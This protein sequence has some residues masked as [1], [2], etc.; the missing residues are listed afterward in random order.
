MEKD[1]KFLSCS[2]AQFKEVFPSLDDYETKDEIE[3]Y[4]SPIKSPKDCGKLIKELAFH[5]PLKKGNSNNTSPSD[6]STCLGHLRR[7][8][9][10]RNI[11]KD[12]QMY[13]KNNNNNPNDQ[14][15]DSQQPK[16]RSKTSTENHLK[17]KQD[18][19]KSPDIFLE[20][21][22]GSVD[23]ID[24]I[25]ASKNGCNVSR[26]VDQYHLELIKR[27]LPGRP[28]QSQAEL[29]DWNDRNDGLGWWPT[30]FFHKQTREFKLQELE[31]SNEEIEDMRNGMIRANCDSEQS[32]KQW[33]EYCLDNEIQ[34]SPKKFPGV[35]IICP[36][37][38]DVVSMASDERRLQIQQMNESL[39]NQGNKSKNS[40]LFPD[41]ANPL[42]TPFI[43]AIQGVSRMERRVACRQGIE[44]SA[45]QNGQ[46]KNIHTKDD[47]CFT[48]FEFYH[49]N[50]PYYINI[51]K[52]IRLPNYPL[53]SII[54][55]MLVLMHRVRILF[56][57]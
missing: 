16:K 29:D 37:T 48:T 33:Y 1:N 23:E 52:H 12:D 20:V 46:V 8:R 40:T 13:S 31:L 19:T 2:K 32:K 47:S 50:P 21:L 44:S 14:D 43:L 3:V 49:L 18:K 24:H 25:L 53:F 6:N 9:R 36:K 4:I 30:I 54:S 22:L 11:K 35:V 42:C 38:K 15:D 45:F 28:A 56:K 51:I 41:L 27:M 34:L 55:S 26:I 17:Q 5:L 39:D 57:K 7:V 10:I